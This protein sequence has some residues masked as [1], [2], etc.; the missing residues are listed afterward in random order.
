MAFCCRAGATVGTSISC[1]NLDLGC[2]GRSCRRT[3]EAI[4]EVI[5]ATSC[6]RA[7]PAFKAT[8]HLRGLRPGGLALFARG[9]GGSWRR[10]E[11]KLHMDEAD[12]LLDA[13]DRVI[14]GFRFGALDKGCLQLQR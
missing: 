2:A 4:C 8:P 3:K 1:R 6:G 9:R 12:G 11:V 5:T 10:G 13:L 14:E 7:G